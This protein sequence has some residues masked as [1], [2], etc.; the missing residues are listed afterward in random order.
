MTAKNGETSGAQYAAFY[1]KKDGKWKISQLIETPLA[2][3]APHD[4]LPSLRGW[5]A[6][7]RKRI[8]ATI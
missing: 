4:Q 6:T 5:L 3:M 1:V 8:R 7:G 2:D